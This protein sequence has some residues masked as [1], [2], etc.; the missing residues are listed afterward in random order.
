M[1][2]KQ[3]HIRDYIVGLVG[4]CVLI[5]ALIVFWDSDK[6]K[7]GETDET[8]DSVN[9]VELEGEPI[10]DMDI[11]DIQKVS[12]TLKDSETVTF[13]KKADDWIINGDENFP[14]SLDSFEQQFL[15]KYVD[16]KVFF[17]L[18]E[19]NSLAEYGIED[20]QVTLV[21]TD[22]DGNNRTYLVGA[23]NGVLSAYY[24]YHEEEKKLYIASTDFFYICRDD[25]YDFAAVDNFP[26]FST[27][28]LEKL[29]MSN[30][31]KKVELVYMEDG[32]E[33]DPFNSSKWFILS[34]FNFYRACDTQSVTD[35]F[36]EL[37]T[38]LGFSHKAD[39]YAT[40]EELKEYG[41]LN[42]DRYYEI[43]YRF[44]DEDEGSEKITVK[45]LFG[46]YNEEQDGYYARIILTQ[47]MTVDSEIA[48]SINFI[49]RDLADKILNLDPV[50]YIYPFVMYVPMKE[51]AGG[52]LNVTMEDG[53]AYEVKYNA[54][55]AEGSSKASDEKI[56][57][58]GTETDVEAYK[59]FYYQLT[60]VY[61]NRPIYN[62]DEIVTSDPVY[63]IKYDRIENDDYYGD[64]V[65]E[66]RAFDSTYYQVTINGK[67]DALVVRRDVDKAMTMLKELN[68]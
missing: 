15:Q 17:E 26:S 53:T 36:E 14:L 11:T 48:R 58:N 23:Y 13:E 34:P 35:N 30:E 1:T 28:S 59:E 38:G 25:I 55:Y 22:N 63:V 62:N 64:A 40:D 60:K 61:V 18:D 49:A 12:Y 33:S 19:Y 29:V 27:N 20:P 50:D 46:N 3:K 8:V 21:V 2:T 54:T 52:G 45:V 47:G 56:T 43:V 7:D 6:I 4:I 32:Y 5:I 57:V 68:N 65:V 10:T 42:S 39:Y 9:V 51:Y 41:L 31:L 24:M 66:Y 16:G 44:E 37:F 67:V